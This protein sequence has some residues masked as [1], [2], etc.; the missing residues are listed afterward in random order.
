MRH[1]RHCCLTALAILITACSGGGGEVPEIPEGFSTDN[2]V[3]QGGVK[4]DMVTKWFTSIQGDIEFN[5]FAT[6]E[7]SPYEWFHGYTFQLEPGDKVVGKVEGSWYGYFAL[8][9]PQMPNGKWGGAQVADWIWWSDPHEQYTTKLDEFTASQAGT[10]LLVVGSP[11]DPYYGYYFTLTCTSGQCGSTQKFCVEY[12]TTDEAGNPLQNFYAINV[13][14]YEAGKQILANVQNFINEDIRTGSCADQSTIYPT[15]WAPVCG[16]PA[17]G[18]LETFGSVYAF[19]VA[20]RQAAGDDSEA[21]GHWELGECLVQCDYNG[22]TY[23][24]GES[25]PATDGCN[26]CSCMENGMV[27]CTKMYCVCNPD[28]EW[29]RKYALLDEQKCWAA[30]IICPAGTAFFTNSCG[31]GCEQDTSCPEVLDC[32]PPVDCTAL[33]MECPY[34]DVAL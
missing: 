33:R 3:D 10:Y 22:F 18:P 4:S 20:I 31:C 16:E 27:A 9:G 13:D 12:E 24:V 6:G 1:L 26:V 7:T 17:G 28:K 15:I 30:K 29:W 11:W 19:K 8:Y 25:F 23:D 14:A 34:S 2:L 5:G 32:E 21:K